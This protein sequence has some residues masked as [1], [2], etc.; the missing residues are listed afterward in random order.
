MNSSFIYLA[1]TDTTVGFLSSNDKKL[2]IAKKRD[3]KQK[4]LQVVDSFQTL[5]QFTRVPTKYK[6]QIRNS[7]LST[8]IYPNSMSF[9]VVLPNNNHYNFIEKFN[10]MYSTSANIT[11]KD[12]N[13]LYAFKKAD[14]ILYSKNGFTQ[15]TSSSI[16][17]VSKQKILKLR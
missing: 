4:T 1:Q 7:K 6:K 2:S 14:I 17:K 9:R 8:Y 3:L 13:E 11:K 15:T 16:Y 5:K 12:F 10:S